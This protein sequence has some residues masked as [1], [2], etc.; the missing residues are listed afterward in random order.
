MAWSEEKRERTV[1]EYRLMKAAKPDWSQRKLLKVTSLGTGVPEITIWR[2]HKHALLFS[3]R[4][5][6]P[7]PRQK[8]G[9]KPKMKPK[10]IN[11]E[12]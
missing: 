5:I 12:V 11:E 10:T 9:P 6:A 8:P 1:N 3:D 7:P 2:W 4:G